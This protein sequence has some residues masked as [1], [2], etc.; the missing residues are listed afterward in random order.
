MKWFV[1][2]KPCVACRATPPVVE[3]TSA[4]V[5]ARQRLP[6]ERLEKVMQATATAA[7]SRAGEGGT[8]QGR[9]IKVVDGSTTQLADTAKNQVEY[10]QPSTQKKGGGFPVM[11]LAVLF[12]RATGAILN[13]VTGH[14][15]SH[16]LR[17]FR[18]RWD[19]LRSGDILM[20][21]RAY[22]E[23]ATMA[24]LKQR[25]VEKIFSRQE[26]GL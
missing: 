4:Y 2:S 6:Q 19:C 20:G 21:D 16:D 17:L 15:H 8:L 23:Y 9:P 24:G 13:V 14:L 1:L 10:P 25:A 11:K 5:Q 18:Q 3:G 7:D 12:S 22:G 26:W